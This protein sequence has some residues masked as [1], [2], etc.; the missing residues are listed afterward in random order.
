[1]QTKP[2]SRQGCLVVITAAMCATLQ[3][4]AAEGVR[5]LPDSAA[6]LGMAGGRFANLVD[7]SVTR[8]NPANLPLLREDALMI[9]VQPWYGQTDFTGLDGRKDSMIEPWK[10]LGSLYA[11]MPIN[12]DM[13]FGLGITAPFGIAISWPRDGAFRYVAPYDA[14]LQTA[15]INPAIGVKLSKSVSFG[16]GLDIFYSRLKLD[17]AFPWMAVTGAPASDGD[18]TFEGDGWG[19]GA[20]AGFTFKLAEHHRLAVTG[21][22]PVKVDYDGDFTIS[23]LPAAVR[24]VFSERSSFDSEIEHP[25]SIGVGYGVDVTDKLT[26]G[27]DYEWIQNSAHGSLPLNIGSNQALLPVSELDLDWRDSCTIGAGLEYKLTPAWILRAGYMFSKSPLQDRTYTPS[28]PTNDRHL[29][30]VG[31]GYTRG[32][33]TIDFAYSFVPMETRHVNGAATPAFDGDYEIEWHVFT[34]SYTRRF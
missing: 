8:S 15:A 29:F 34:L 30:S 7:P 25:G 28:I 33:H 10:P 24:G 3:T 4:Q 11:V 31:A 18:M 5:T 2:T 23:N 12:D 32:R 27:I 16:V 14:V 13:T 17:Q 26:F 9:N 20:Y 21:R 19:L 1:M 6:A 22:L